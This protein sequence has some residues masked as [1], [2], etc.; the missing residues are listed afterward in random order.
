MVSRPFHQSTEIRNREKPVWS[1]VV[2]SI[3]PSL[4]IYA[5]SMCKV[6]SH[7]MLWTHAAKAVPRKRVMVLKTVATV[8]SAVL[9]S[10]LAQAVRQAAAISNS[11][12][13]TL[14]PTVAPAGHAPHAAHPEPL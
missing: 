5:V 6:T 1:R 3:A 8:S 7:A 11:K 10:R 12:S 2:M 14:M 4:T 9:V 13:A